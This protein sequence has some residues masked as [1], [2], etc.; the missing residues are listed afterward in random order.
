MGIINKFIYNFK[1]SIFILNK[2]LF[3]WRGLYHVSLHTQNYLFYKGY[4]PGIQIYN[5]MSIEN[6][7]EIYK[8]D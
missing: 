2:S 5:D 8:Q 4:T 1:N 3:Y 6:Y 7:T